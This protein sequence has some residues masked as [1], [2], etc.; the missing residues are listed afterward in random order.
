MRVDAQSSASVGCCSSSSLVSCLSDKPV[1]LL[2]C[3][4]S[5]LLFVC[6][7]LGE[8]GSEVPEAEGI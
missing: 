3:A 5:L 7:P 6:A 2:S 8:S 4:L 1:V